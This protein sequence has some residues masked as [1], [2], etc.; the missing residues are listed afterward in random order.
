MFGVE[1]DWQVKEVE[2]RALG[3]SFGSM[4]SGKQ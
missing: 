2:N 3:L 4:V 1:Y